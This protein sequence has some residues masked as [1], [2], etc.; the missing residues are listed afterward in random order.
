[1][2][3]MKYFPLHRTAIASRL[4]VFHFPFS[5]FHRLAHFPSSIAL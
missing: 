2:D 3:A 1:M 5:I 4:A